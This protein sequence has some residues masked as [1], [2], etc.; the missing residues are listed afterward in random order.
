[1]KPA[2][3]MVAESMSEDPAVALN[4]VRTS[5]IGT[6]DAGLQIL[7]VVVKELSTDQGL[8]VCITS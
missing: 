6:C 1:V 7:N 8:R 3:R 4:S 5:L 2:Q